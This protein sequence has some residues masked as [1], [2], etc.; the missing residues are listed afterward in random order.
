MSCVYSYIES[1]QISDLEKLRL[2]SAHTEIFKKAKE[3][4][5]FRIFDNRFYSLKEGYSKALSFVANINKEYGEIV[6]KLNTKAPGQ[7]FLSINVLSLQ[8]EGQQGELFYQL[9]QNQIKNELQSI[10]QGNG[11][12]TEG[13]PIQAAK[14]N[15]RG[16]ETTSL[17]FAQE[18]FIKQQEEKRLKKYIDDN[19]LWYKEELD[20]S[21]LV[22]VGNAEQYV[23]LNPDNGTV[24]KLNDKPFY[25]FWVDYLNNLLLHNYF[26]PSVSY[27]LLGFKEQDFKIYAVV[28]QPFVQNDKKVNLEDVEKFLF[29]KGFSKKNPLRNDY[30]NEEIGIV[31]EDLHDENVLQK[32]EQLFFIDT[33]FY[34]TS[35]FF[36]DL[37]K[38]TQFQKTNSQQSVA[39]E[40]TL[41]KVKEVAK[42]MGIDIQKLSE[43]T[44]SNDIGISGINAIADVTRGIIAIAE[45]KEGEALTEETV[46]I[47]TA[48][49]EQTHPQMV[50]EMI[51]KIDRFKIFKKTLEE[52]KSNKNYQLPN[53]KPDIRKIKKEAVDKLIA[54][55]IVNNNQDEE[56]FPELREEINQSLV[57]RWWNSILDYIKGI[58]RKANI[59]IFEKVAN[60]ILNKNIGDISD[61]VEEGV[62][63]QLSDKQK[64]IQQKLQ[65]TKDKIEKVVE[66][67]KTDPLLLDSE[68]AN[69]FY[70]IQ[71]ADGTF[72]KITK[73]VTDRVKAWYKQRFGNKVFSEQEKEFNELK[74]KYGVEG[75]ADFQEIH[76][77]YYNENGTKKEIPLERTEK[78]HLPSQDVYDKLEKYYVSLINDFPEGTLIFSEV[79]IYDDKQKE[80]GTID[81]LAIEP[82]GK[83]N[84]L[85][86]KFMNFGKGQEDVAW[87]KQ[88][89]YNV[90]IG[91]YKEILN[92]NYGIKEFGLLRAIPIAMKFENENKKDK[93]S[94]LQ[95]TG[96]AIG[97]VNPSEIQSLKL[98]PVAEES[99]STGYEALDN[100]IK[101]LNAHLRQVS[102]EK[103]ST[104]EE[105]QF[106]IERLNTLNKAIR[107]AHITHNVVPLIDVIEVMRKEGDRILED[108]NTIYKDKPATLSDSTDEQ[109]SEFANE[110]RDYIKLSEVFTEI[111]DDLGSMI[112]T[113]DMKTKAST[114]AEKQEALRRKSYLDKL[115][116]ESKL[117][118]R[119]QKAITKAATA[120]ADKHIGERNL[121]TG[122]LKPEKIVKGLGSL[123]RGVSELPLRSL[124]ILHKLTRAAQGKASTDALK[125]INTLIDIRKKLS[126]KGSDLR[127]LI[128]NIYQK[129]DKGK[130]VNKLIYKYNNEFFKEIDKKALEGGDL[131][132]IKDNINVEEYK[133]EAQKVIDKQV[134]SIDRNRY[135]GTPEEEEHIKDVEKTKV[136]KLYDIDRKDF[137]GWN[138]YILKRHPLDKWYSDEYKNILKDNDLLELYNFVV[139]FNEKA[140]DIGYINNKIASS[141]LPF[142]RKSMAEQVSFDGE[143]SP[144]KNFGKNLKLNIEDVGYGNINEVTGELENSI[145]KYY[146]HDFSY[147][148]D[149]VNDYSEVSEDLFKNLILYIQQVEKYKY[150]SEIEGQLKLI[151]TIE[152]F[153][154]H[155][156][157]GRTGNVIVKDGKAQELP[158]NAENAKM[159]DD[160]L[161]VLL[162]DQRYVLS[163]SDTPLHF[164]KV[165]NFAKKSVNRVAGK[166]IWKENEKA[167]PTSML[168]TMDAVNRGFQMKTL[169]FEFISGA[170]NAFGGNIQALTQAGN[171]FGASEFLKNETKLIGE[172]FANQ[173]EKDIF[174]QLINTFMPLKDDPA[175]EIYKEAGLTTLT[176]RNF[177]D[178]LMVFMRKPEQLIEKAVFLSLL[179]NTMVIDGKI[180][181]IREFVKNKYKD[182][183]NSASSYQNVKGKIDSEIEE[184]K[185][186]SSINSTKKLVDGKLVIPGLNL[187]NREELQRLTNLSRRIAR[188]A[189]GGMTDGDINRMS[190]SIW[191]KSM[192]IFKGWIPKLADT[193][194]SEFRKVSDDFSVRINE[195]GIA[196]GQKYDIGRIRLLAYVLSDGIFKGTEN[197]IN[198]LKLNQ[199]GLNKL[200]ELFEEFKQK[201]EVETGETLNMSRE[202]FIDLIRINLRN[203]MKELALLIGLLGVA[204]SLGFIAPDDDEDKA[205]KNFHRYAQRVVDKFVNE[206]SFFYNPVELENLLNGGIFPAIG[207]AGDIKRFSTHFFKEITGLDFDPNTSYDDVRKRAQPIKYGM[208][209]L[210]I[211]KSAL[212][213]AA[214][215][216][217][218]VAKEFQ[219]TIQKNS[220]R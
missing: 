4:G 214:I 38:N 53:G 5:V 57:R 83:A 10:I 208:R 115:E 204:L 124:E 13:N 11:N 158:G 56:Q 9:D 187:E 157:T 51:A 186:T 65:L 152:E 170:V 43:Y 146:T 67:G 151:K 63:F 177:G 197:L 70:R 179:E 75:H 54:E 68:E 122:L 113:E 73:R 171:Y 1:A 110:M 55:I 145:P 90:Q 212:T 78:F 143:F 116:E 213:Y 183:Y 125:E 155:L 174:I 205:T 66:E 28:E 216:N 148:G 169:G 17:G 26:F 50:T 190:M 138:N 82:S 99:E 48:I 71:K 206:L 103:V 77:R 16:D 139:N 185:K 20:K 119:S 137:N 61:I 202:D 219:V 104:E 25:G 34:L 18:K 36:D 64:D 109:L 188:N 154:N 107:Q 162:Y 46:H 173:E 198:I 166:E 45:G 191:T 84:I 95:L 30:I 129:D 21:K 74:R 100:I 112:Y 147:K 114:D 201:Y 47:A 49:L 130:I 175:Y 40:D 59:D 3:S 62:Y 105:K 37:S 79:I 8:K 118:R 6:A 156:N 196:E 41:K 159:F 86:W 101:R 164:D 91:R 108:Y 127:K 32:D 178:D 160:F 58:Y 194:F 96:I 102:K 141:F 33:V 203:Q 97:S 211:F 69:N 126:A 89:A 117:I 199:G 35:K 120:F 39:S 133:K 98:L 131:Q 72:E 132:W 161:R 44:K 165:L 106:K 140:K 94:P 27:K 7:H 80:A 128:Q 93:K 23:Y 172:R 19:N 111:G 195:D 2:N 167:S 136:R 87:Y 24:I 149:G 182:R 135:N 88:G 144:I 168:K 184:L 134:E 220:N 60:K 52:Y 176:R 180:V 192:M 200:D 142:V 123:F 42:K 218:D 76:S 31:L 22:D 189:T 12:Q 150:M 121:I 29:N 81:F 153:K 209:M 215:F 217:E 193:R 210:P 14:T 163:D 15:I 85:D 207:L 92:K 181:N